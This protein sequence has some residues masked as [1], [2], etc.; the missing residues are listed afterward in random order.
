MRRI[1]LAALGVLCAAGFA[2]GLAP[3]ASAH[4]LAQSSDPAEGSTVEQPPAAVTVTF[5]EPP[6]P[7]LSTIRVLD[8]AG[9]SYDAGPT[10]AVSGNPDALRVAV[11]PLARGV[12]TVS[13]RTVSTVDGHFAT[14][15]FAFGVG[16][17]AQ[18]AATAGRATSSGAPP[19]SALAVAGRWM[20]FAGLLLLVGAGFAA[21][22]LF[23][24]P[25]SST[26]P[27]LVIGWLLTA[28]G[29]YGVAE[30]QRAA[31]GVSWS[32]VFST[33]LGHTLITRIIPTAIAGL[34]VLSVWLRRGRVRKAA[35]VV[36]GLAAAGA[37]WADAAASHAGGQSPAMFN[38]LAQWLHVVAVGLW[39]GGLA[40]VLLGVRGLPSPDR[41]AAARRLSTTA[42]ITLVVVAATGIARSVVE[43]Q[44]WGNLAGTAFGKLV[45][46]K[47]ALIGLLALLG[48]V[49]RLRSVPAAART[50]RGLRVVGST[51]VVVGATALLVA[52]ALVNVAPPVSSAQAATAVAQ[53]L[54]VTG[55]DDA[56]TV[57][58]RLEVSPGTPGFN[59]F[60]LHVTDYDT[61]APVS[62]QT[63]QLEFR[64]P[65]RPDVGN[66]TLALAGHGRGTW[67]GRGANLSI[68]G[69]WEVTA[70]VERGAESAEV[71]LRL[72]T[73]SLP[74]KI[75]VSRVPGEPTLYTI[76]LAAGRTVQVY[77]DPNKLGPVEFHS[78]FFDASGNELPVTSATITM[79]PPSAGA[80]PQALPTRQLE[81]GHYVADAILGTG[82]YRFDITG[83]TS[84]GE[85]IAI[86]IDITAGT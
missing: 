14:G 2:V 55:T 15:A 52:A 40:A 70:L 18:G 11:K 48:A 9:Q 71:P 58:A 20:L 65:A 21:L 33:S 35:I 7:K 51:E 46:L 66:S 4:A 31:A 16:V 42:L 50:L 10:Q 26:L 29:T 6:D 80:Q 38:L 32:D 82:S 25:P 17:A 76:H 74:Q 84:S 47:L 3:A 86:H 24:V 61:G 8:T 68:D 41:A 83:T 59:R 12:Y 72:T 75:D 81:P 53:P 49:N 13:W 85:T 69:S 37:M 39:I 34:G 28:A 57:R 30:A 77:I 79:T 1:R 64:M 54:V 63:V 36:T 22:M 23:R 62:A 56:T 78:T 60:R 73:R 44:S 27:L 45:I 19:P 43:V 67:M 5:G